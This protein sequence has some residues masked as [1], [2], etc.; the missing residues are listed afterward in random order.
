MDFQSIALPA[1]LSTRTL[2]SNKLRP[3]QAISKRQNPG[4]YE[5]CKCFGRQ[6]GWDCIRRRWQ[7]KKGLAAKLLR[8]GCRNSDST[9]ANYPDYPAL[10]F[11]RLAGRTALAPKPILRWD[12]AHEAD[13][14]T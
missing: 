13:S 4:F 2:E 14:I 10:Q 3:L 5:G 1:E 9:G 6:A 8:Q 12:I 7:Y 11:L